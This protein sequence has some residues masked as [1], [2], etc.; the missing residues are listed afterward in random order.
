M[1]NKGKLQIL[2]QTSERE[3]KKRRKTVYSKIDNETRTKLVKMML[4]NKY[5]L[6]DAAQYLNINY[7]TAKTILRV[8]RIEKR[9]IKKK[10]H[11]MTKKSESI[12][13]K[14]LSELSTYV[15]SNLNNSLCKNFSPQYDFQCPLGKIFFFLFYSFRETERFF[16]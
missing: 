2:P 10:Y 16:I 11:K 7:S 5:L 1:D 12:E 15:N 9:M 13:I 8:F 4:S 6:K 14:I 3:I